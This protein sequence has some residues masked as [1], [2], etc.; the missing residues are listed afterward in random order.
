[1][2]MR[3]A[4]D[5]IAKAVG[6][7]DLTYEQISLA[8]FHAELRRN[9]VSANVADMRAEVHQVAAAPTALIEGLPWSVEPH[10]GFNDPI[11]S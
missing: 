2:S 4:T 7:D 11:S 6:A 10:P 3:E 1:M 5:A 9:G 8:A